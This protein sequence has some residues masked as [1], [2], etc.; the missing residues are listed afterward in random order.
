MITSTAFLLGSQKNTQIEMIDFIRSEY[1]SGSIYCEGGNYFHFENPNGVLATLGSFPSFIGLN[2]I[3]KLGRSNSSFMPLGIFV[4]QWHKAF[5]NN[6]TPDQLVDTVFRFFSA[7]LKSGAYP[8]KHTGHMFHH[9]VLHLR[10][11]DPAVLARLME[12]LLTPPNTDATKDEKSQWRARLSVL[13]PQYGH[14]EVS[15]SGLNEILLER[16]GGEQGMADWFKQHV[17]A[18]VIGDIAKVPGMKFLLSA[19]NNSG[20]RKFLGDELSL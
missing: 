14:G 12:A 15:D 18:K 5:D 3:N 4:Y 13:A 9:L 2:K 11:E 19:M 17:P 7:H 10:R 20:K 16:L 6:A 1:K 8:K